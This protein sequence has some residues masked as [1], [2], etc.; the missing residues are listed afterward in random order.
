MAH[1]IVIRGGMVADGNGGEPQPAD[2]AIDGDRVVAV[3]QVDERGTREI[4]AE[5]RLVTPGFVDIHTHLDAQLSWD[6][7]GTSSC[8]HGVTS[9]VLGNCGVTFAPCKPEDRR[10]LAEMMES[11]EDIPAD[12][13]MSGLDWEW[14]SYGEYLTALDK[15]PKGVNA[16]GMVGHCAVRYYA[17]GER[18]L[19]E[20]PAGPDDIRAMQALVD[21]AISAGALGFSTSRTFLHRVPDG[22][23][24]PGTY[25]AV[26]ELM[27]LA[28]PMG[29]QHRG[30][31]EA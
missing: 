18:S 9:V 24:V 12:S 26:E 11:V 22:R 23:P 25:A 1:D 7:A 6:P 17:M 2:V 5:G 15:L 31:F 8:W 4:D 3:G 27:A 29:R 21:E 30:V 14:E 13:I 10:Y 20:E 16:G 19:D 28:E